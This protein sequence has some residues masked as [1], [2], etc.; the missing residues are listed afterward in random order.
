AF[1]ASLGAPCATGTPAGAAELPGSEALTSGQ[2]APPDPELDAPVEE[3]DPP[4]PARTP[5]DTAAVTVNERTF[6]SCTGTSRGR[7]GRHAVRRNAPYLRSAT[8]V[9]PLRRY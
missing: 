9:C 8:D 1:F 5:T 2:L 3:P 6:L 4:Q 7:P